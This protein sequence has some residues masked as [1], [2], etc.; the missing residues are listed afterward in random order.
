MYKKKNLKHREVKLPIRDHTNEWY[1]Q[2]SD[3]ARLA[4][5]PVSLTNKTREKPRKSIMKKKGREGRN[6]H[7][8]TIHIRFKKLKN[9]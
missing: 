7:K 1:E 8:G 2:D 9:H 6:C 4:P 5:L 3:P